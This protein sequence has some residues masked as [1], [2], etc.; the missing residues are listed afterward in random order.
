[1][2]FHEF[3]QFQEIFLFFQTEDEKTKN[4]KSA[5]LS[6]RRS[7]EEKPTKKRGRAAKAESKN[8]KFPKVHI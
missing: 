3:Q 1:M 8:S 6:D 5:Q 7:I 4:V 2:R